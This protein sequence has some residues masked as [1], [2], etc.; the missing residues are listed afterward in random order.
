MHEPSGRGLSS[1][2]LIVRATTLRSGNDAHRTPYDPC[3]HG[4]PRDR[5]RRPPVPS[6][7]RGAGRRAR[8]RGSRHR[9]ARD[10]RRRDAGPAERPG[11]PERTGP[12]RPTPDLG[13]NVT[14]FTPDTPQTEIQAKLDAIAAR[15]VPNQ[16]GEERDAVLFAP[17]TY[18]STDEAA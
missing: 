13:P 1:D 5:R 7:S 14:L 12:D 4:W 2:R 9:R 8:P 11:T 6:S 17:G 3:P 10:T 15:Q 16:F 18:G